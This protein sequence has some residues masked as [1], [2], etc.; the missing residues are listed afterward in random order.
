MDVCP[1]LRFWCLLVLASAGCSADGARSPAENPPEVEA[2]Q[3]TAGARVRIIGA[4][5]E[6]RGEMTEEGLAT[7]KRLAYGQAIDTLVVDSA[8][9]E[10]V[11]GMDFGNWVVERQLNV[12]VDGVCLSSC[13]NYVFTAGS[14]KSILPGSVVAWHGS[15][16]QPGLLDQM[17]AMIEKDVKARRLPPGKEAEELVRAR[18]KNVDYLTGA[19]VKQGEFFHRVGVDEYVTRIGNEVYGLPGFYYLSVEDMARFGIRD[20]T[21]PDNYAQMDLSALRRRTGHAIR[22]LKLPSP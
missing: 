20:V 18:Q 16:K 3:S 4:S 5:M 17:H 7:L 1:M 10:I 2:G 22:Y 13:A 19:I 9:G 15:A 14:K 21:A 8:G 12:V 11:V 6:Y